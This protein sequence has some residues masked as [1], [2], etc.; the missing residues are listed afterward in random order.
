MTAPHRTVAVPDV[1]A[2]V[3]GWRTW[4]VG[5][6]AQHRHTLFSPL[7]GTP[8][9]AGRPMVATCASP[10]HTPPGDACPCGLYAVADTGT[11]GWS[12][13]DHEVLGVVAL[14]GEVVEG[15]HGWRASHAYP[16][17]LVAGPGVSAEQRAVVTRRYGVPVHTAEVS[18]RVLARRLDRSTADVLRHVDD[19]T[20]A[21]DLLTEVTRRR[22][23]VPAPRRRGWRSWLTS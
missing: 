10:R 22:E 11:L 14:W 9:P 21:A 16:R 5:R 19:P 18:P 6:R 17:F 20:A 13:S 15:E 1:P 4:R 23:P 12:P 7:T 8:W 2:A 3:L